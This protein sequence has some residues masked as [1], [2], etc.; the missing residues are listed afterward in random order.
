[1]KIIY[2]SKSTKEPPIIAYKCDYCGEFLSDFKDEGLERII[3]VAG[4]MDRMC[5]RC[6]KELMKKDG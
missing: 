6:C 2:K 3:T 1:M 5:S 4:K